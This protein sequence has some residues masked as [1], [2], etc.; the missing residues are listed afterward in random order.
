MG[1]IESIGIVG[2]IHGNELLGVYL[3][4]KFRKF[5]Q[6]IDRYGFRVTTL[7]ANP[8]AIESRKRYIDTDL[9]RCFALQDLANPALVN[10]EQILAKKIDKKP[11]EPIIGDRSAKEY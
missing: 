7:L 6:L 4:K 1:K 5:P 10:Y 9:N 8:Q 11:T 2:G 3:V